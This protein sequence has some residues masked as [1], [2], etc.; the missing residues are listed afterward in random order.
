MFEI[1]IAGFGGQ[2]IMSLGQLLTYAGMAEGKQVSWMPSYGPE[3]RGG[4]ANC[5]VVLADGEEIGSPIVAEPDVAIIMNGPSLDKFEA[6]VRKGGYLVVNSSLMSRS[7]TRTDIT[8][9][10]VPATELANEMGNARI[11]GM[12]TLGATVG[13]TG[14]LQMES[15]HEALAHVLKP[16]LIPMNIEALG[17]GQALAASKAAAR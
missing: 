6:T 15:L 1:L 14:M 4:A 12:I 11:A 5:S 3:Q 17:R 13:L 16:Q 2:G 8:V 10:E 7:P 9:L